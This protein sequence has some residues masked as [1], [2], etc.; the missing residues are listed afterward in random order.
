MVRIGSDLNEKDNL[1]ERKLVMH[2]YKILHGGDLNENDFL[3]RMLFIS[4]FGIK[5][6]RNF[7]MCVGGTWRN[8]WQAADSRPLRRVPPTAAEETEGVILEASPTVSV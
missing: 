7:S 3:E 5:G 4:S 8:C 2:G 6:E 1:N